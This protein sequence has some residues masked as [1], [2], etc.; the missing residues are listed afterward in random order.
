[1]T[2][3]SELDPSALRVRIDL[4]YDGTGYAGWARQPTLPTIQGELERALTQIDDRIGSVVCAGRTDAGVHARSQVVHVDIPGDVWAGRGPDGLV[5]QLNRFTGPQ[6]YVRTAQAAP[7]GFDARFSALSRAYSYRLCDDH[8][9]WDPL[10][11]QWV[12]LHRRPLDAAAMA[13]AAP[14]LVGEH[15]FAAFCRP[16][17]GASTVRRI[18]RLDV[19]RDGGRRVVVTVESDAFCHSMVRSLVGALVAVGEGRKDPE[20]PGRVLRTG[21][22]DP[23]VMVM[24]PQGLILE[25]VAYPPDELVAER[26]EVTRAF[27]GAPEPTS[28]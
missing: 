22:R 15:D 7:N 3:S 24:P 28:G 11:R 4:G 17:E 14:E 13:L 9:A 21:R 27:R 2:S 12:T 25:S 10:F 20:W 5:H 8:N 6:I 16:R 19:Y 26:A 18:L 1:M 23:G